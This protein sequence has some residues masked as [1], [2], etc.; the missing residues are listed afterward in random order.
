MLRQPL[1][2][3]QRRA[4][5]AATTRSASR[6]V[7]SSR[8]TPSTTGDAVGRRP[9]RPSAPVTV[10][11][12]ADVDAGLGERPRGAGPTRRWCGG[13][14]APRGPRRPAAARRGRRSSA[15]SCTPAASS[16]SST[17]G[18]WSRSSTTMRARNPW[19]WWTCGAPRR[20]AANG[21]LGVGVGGERVRARAA[22][23]GGRPGPSASAAARPP[24]PPPTTTMALPG[25]P[26]PDCVLLATPVADRDDLRLW[27]RALPTH[28]DSA[29]A[30]AEDVSRAS[31]WA[32]VSPEDRRAERRGL[33]LDAA[34]ELLGTDGLVRDHRPGRLPAGP[35]STPATSTRASPTS[36]RSS[37]PSTT[38]SSSSSPT[39]VVTH[40]GRRA[41]R[42]PVADPRRDR[43]RHRRL[44]R[45]R[46]PP[47]AR[48]LRRGPRQRGPQPAA[49]RDRPRRS[50]DFVGARCGERASAPRRRAS[51]SA[52]SPPRS[53]SAGSA[54]S[55]SPGS[56]VGIDVT[57]DQLVDDATALFLALG[58]TAA[59]IA[60][61]RSWSSHAART[62]AE[63]G[64]S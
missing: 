47:G 39:T 10:D 54:S 37:S 32:G 52:A 43:G 41:G 2:H 38:G 9:A 36:T 14:S 18:K 21:L 22:S 16:A 6:T 61:R 30:V 44:R 49:D 48:A 50:S 29:P 33:L 56:T 40:D 60:S 31:R 55:S 8:S 4:P 23:P 53:S 35:S 13:R 15:S 27:S 3:R 63:E 17:S 28:P 34:F 51:T 64:G 46:P 12:G 7:P 62:D 57:R 42:P 45:R 19:V 58:E 25:P 20:S 24:T 5:S 1:G 26:I 11:A 59:V